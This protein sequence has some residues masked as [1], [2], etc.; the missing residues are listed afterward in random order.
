M[1]LDN[2]AAG[3]TDWSCVPESAHQDASGTVRAR[4]VPFGEIQL[5][6]IEFSTDYVAQ[7]WCSKGHIVFVVTGE[8]TIEHQNGQRYALG[9]GMSYQVGDNGGPPHRVRS[10]SGA[11]VF[12]VD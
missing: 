8:L 3:V 2:I 12:V 7:E 1:R 4:T 11:R 5:R 9:P 10:Q 6:L